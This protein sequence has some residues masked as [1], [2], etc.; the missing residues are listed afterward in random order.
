MKTNNE[1]LIK[2]QKELNELLGDF[3]NKQWEWE[4]ANCFT[5]RDMP[6]ANQKEV[7][8]KKRND[9]DDVAEIFKNRIK[10][11]KEGKQEAKE[12]I[13]TIKEYMNSNF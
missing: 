13:S 5:E 10:L 9:L 6:S 2:E 4:L 8:F 12:I 3:R 11:H 1:N 7:Y